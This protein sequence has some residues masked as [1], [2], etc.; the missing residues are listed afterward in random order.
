MRIGLL[1]F[2][3]LLLGVVLVAERHQGA[4]VNPP[5]NGVTL[6]KIVTS[7][8]AT[9][10]PE[11]MRAKIQGWNMVDASTPRPLSKTGRTSHTTH[12]GRP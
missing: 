8:A 12:T 3:V 4:T 1:V 11:A 6:P 2:T 9:Y 10:T 5:G 7:V